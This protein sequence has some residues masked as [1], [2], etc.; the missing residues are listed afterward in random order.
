[1]FG[2][3]VDTANADVS[4]SFAHKQLNSLRCLLFPSYRLVPALNVIATH[5][6]IPSDVAGATLMAA[7][8]CVDVSIDIRSLVLLQLSHP[9]L[10]LLQGASSPELFSSLVSL[11]ITHSS[12]GL[13]TIV[14]SEIFN[15]LVICAGAVYASKTGTLVLD[16]AI[17]IREV[18]FYALGIGL[19]YF[20]L[21][22]SRVDS[23]DVEEGVEHIYVSFLDAALLVGGYLMYVGVCANMELIEGWFRRSSGELDGQDLTR[24]KELDVNGGGNEYENHGY[25]SI[26][27]MAN[28]ERIHKGVMRAVGLF[29]LY[30]PQSHPSF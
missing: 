1:M 30:Q 29:D 10:S 14:G 13:G 26:T 19:L 17:V 22:D 7:V 28:G 15:Q 25:G 4:V 8:R 21:K 9:T 27:T 16:R 18:G 11:F 3:D 5:Y 12:L 23:E 6:N 2:V 20:A 24:L